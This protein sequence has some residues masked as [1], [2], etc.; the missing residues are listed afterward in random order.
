MIDSYS[1]DAEST[2]DMVEHLENLQGFYIFFHKD[3]QECPWFYTDFNYQKAISYVYD[4]HMQHT[5]KLTLSKL[6]MPENVK[7]SLSYAYLL[8]SAAF[9][10]SPLVIF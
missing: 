1:L 6:L 3:I 4:P 7:V 9:I 2:V 8:S 5:Q 10:P